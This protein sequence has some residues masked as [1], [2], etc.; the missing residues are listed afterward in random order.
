[1]GAALAPFPGDAPLIV[2]EPLKDPGYA[3]QVLGFRGG[4]AMVAGMAAFA[5]VAT[6]LVAVPLG[7][8]PSRVSLPQRGSG[9]EFGVEAGTGWGVVLASAPRFLYLD[10]GDLA[11]IDFNAT[12][13]GPQVS[14]GLDAGYRLDDWVTGLFVR[15]WV[16]PSAQAGEPG[17]GAGSYGFGAN[18]AG[19][20]GGQARLAPPH[21]DVDVTGG[22]GIA[23]LQ[24][25]RG[26]PGSSNGPEVG[27]HDGIG[28]DAFIAIGAPMAQTD[29]VT[30]VPRVRVDYVWSEGTDSNRVSWT[31]MAVFPT[32][33]FAV[34]FR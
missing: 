15:A 2:S 13:V 1:M 29:S 9:W 21:W 16:V 6:C 18:I 11:A 25:G 34:V 17:T 23:F 33:V 28:F 24:V 32:A 19:V 27:A 10:Q 7:A 14:L 31:N 30:L 8:S 20:F 4:R 5:A 3:A 26:S 12:A 22:A